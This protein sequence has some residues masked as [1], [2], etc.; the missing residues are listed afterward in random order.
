MDLQSAKIA[1]K[2]LEILSI[3]NGCI[4]AR[5]GACADFVRTSDTSKG[6]GSGAIHKDSKNRQTALQNLQI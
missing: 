2:N 3:K 1:L 5:S 4:C 6:I